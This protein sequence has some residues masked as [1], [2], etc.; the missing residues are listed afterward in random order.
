MTKKITDRPLKRPGR[1]PTPVRSTLNVNY[2]LR[3]GDVTIPSSH[4]NV[5]TKRNPVIK[6]TWHFP[7]G[8][9][10]SDKDEALTIA[11]KMANVR[12]LP[13]SNHL[14]QPSRAYRFLREVWEHGL[15]EDDRI[16][17]NY[18]TNGE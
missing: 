17:D 5:G 12:T 1:R 6:V 11:G 15:Y 9:S 10:T 7:G 16:G 13:T 8:Y 18:Y 3:I 14:V 2:D 4:T